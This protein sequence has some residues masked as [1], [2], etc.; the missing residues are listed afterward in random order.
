MFDVFSGYT[1]IFLTSKSEAYS[2]FLSFKATSEKL[3]G[4]SIRMLQTDWGGEFQ[5]LTPYRKTQGITHR[6]SCPHT[7]QQNGI[8]ERKHRHIFD[9]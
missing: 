7:S 8:L 4:T 2:T 5:S 9:M 3:L 1:W 6:L